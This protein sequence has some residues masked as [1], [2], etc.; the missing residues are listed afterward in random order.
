MGIDVGGLVGGA[1][2]IALAEAVAD[3]AVEKVEKI[4]QEAQTGAGLLAEEV[5]GMTQFQPFS[6]VT[7]LGGADVSATGG[8][9][10][11][12]S[13]EQQALQNQLFTR[14]QGLFDFAATDPSESQAEMYETLRGLQRPEEERARLAL[15]ERMLSQGRLGLMSDAYGGAT[16]EML[17]QAQAQEQAKLQASLGARDAAM[18]ERQQA[19][20]AGQG[21]MSL[22]YM[23]QQQALASLGMGSELAKL[24]LTGQTAG[25]ELFGQLSQ[26]GLE[27][28]IQAQQLAA[29]IRQAQI[30]G[31]FEAMKGESGGLGSQIADAL[32]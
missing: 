20:A 29:M 11:N 15:E 16:P 14:A 3:K 6:I 21:L 13:P 30:T 18:A 27:S 31:L 25:A 17:A 5:S 32:L 12:L 7:G 28:Q 24:G 10:L 8:Y 19:L 26:T 22:G 2:D 1:L 23:P 4:G 9:D